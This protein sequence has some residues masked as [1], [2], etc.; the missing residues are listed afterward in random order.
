VG[1]RKVLRQAIDVVE[2]TVR[3]VFVLLVELVVVETF[4]V[5]FGTLRSG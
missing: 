3:L 2:V 1:A 5:E 4:V